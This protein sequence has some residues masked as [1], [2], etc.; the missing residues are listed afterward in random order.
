MVGKILLVL[1]AAILLTLTVLLLIPLQIH[2]TYQEKKLSV[3][4]CYG[5]KRFTLYPTPEKEETPEATSDVKESEKKVPKEK[6]QTACRVNWEQI[7]YSLEVL[8]GILLRALR[9]TGQR[10]VISPLII[11]VLVATDDPADTALL[12]GRLEG[13]LAA[14]LPSLHREVRIRE[15]DIRLC[16]DFCEE[17]MDYFVD[18]GIRIRPWDLVAT[19]LVAVGGLIKW[20]IGYKK[21]ADQSG[22]QKKNT[23]TAASPESTV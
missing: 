15:Q 14:V 1:L 7:S 3:R 20:Y 23:N 22:E 10:I 4:G 2:V 11:H 6:K 12:Y 13:T 19:A 8:P 17:H 21:R 5:P 9:M 16:P 18:A